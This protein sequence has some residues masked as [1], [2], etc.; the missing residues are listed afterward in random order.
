MFDC[1]FSLKTEINAELMPFADRIVDRERVRCALALARQK[2]IA[3]A[4]VRLQRAWVDDV[5]EVVASIDPDIYHR[6]GA[7]YGY[8]TVN[9]P[10]FLKCLLRD[11]EDL[12]VQSR[13]R[14]TMLLMPGQRKPD[15]HASA[16]GQPLIIAG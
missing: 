9:D 1:S 5:G 6:L 16:L 10:D 4:N 15:V 12:R 7:I 2:R 13:S 8:E 11:N 3:A 14:K